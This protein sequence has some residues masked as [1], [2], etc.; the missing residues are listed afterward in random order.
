AEP[1]RGSA[2]SLDVLMGRLTATTLALVGAE[3]RESSRG[4]LTASPA[5]M[6]EYLHGMAAWRGFGTADAT[7]AFER[8]F[9]QDST[10]ARA[11]FMRYWIAS[12]FGQPVAGRW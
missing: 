8:A 9:A 11:A 10:F 2:D 12:W 4:V 1:V 5:A 6:R 7:A 3:F